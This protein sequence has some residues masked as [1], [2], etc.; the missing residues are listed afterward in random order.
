MGVNTYE[1]WNNI[2]LCCFHSGQYDMALSCLNR[3]LEL[4]D[5]E[6]ASDVW[7]NIGHVGVSLGDLGL[8]YQAWKVCVT[9]KPSHT[10]ALNNIGVLEIRR[11]KLDVAKANIISSKS[12]GEHLYEPFYNAGKKIIK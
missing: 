8:A 6:E 1:L 12:M 5:G 3:S 10:E 11:Q 9:V 7:Y 2:G 4:A